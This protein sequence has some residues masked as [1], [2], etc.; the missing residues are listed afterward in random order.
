MAADLNI[1]ATLQPFTD[2]R[3]D[4]F[5]TL[6]MPRAGLAYLPA[7]GEQTTGKLYFTWGQHLEES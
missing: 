2:I 5:G 6:E 1:A 3:G 7:Q 4:L